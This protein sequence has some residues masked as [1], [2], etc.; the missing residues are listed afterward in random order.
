MRIIAAA[1]LLASLVVSGMMASQSARA[2]I[3]APVPPFKGNDTGG[4]IAYSM[5]T[6]VDARQVAVDHCARYGKVAKFLGVQAYEGGY[7][8]FACRWVPYGAAD[9]PIR[10]LY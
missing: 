8:S 10:T 9:R 3:F 5:A 1:G 6:Q 7:I 2:D 4:I